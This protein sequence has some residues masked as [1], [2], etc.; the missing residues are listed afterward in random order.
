MTFAT[1]PTRKL[2]KKKVPN[3][4]RVFPLF[5]T[6]KKVSNFMRG[7]EEEEERITVGRSGG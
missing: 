1:R 5:P 2:K 3:Q 4:T 7:E 6:K